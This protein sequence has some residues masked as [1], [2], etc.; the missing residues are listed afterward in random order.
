[1]RTPGEL[2][3]R[4]QLRDYLRTIEL[5]PELERERESDLARRY[6]EQGDRRAADLVISAHL[7]DVVAIARRYR[8]Y[9]QP[10]ADLIAAGN[11]GLVRALDRFDPDRGWRFMTYASY[12]V[13]AEILE[14]IVSTWSA[15][16]VGKSSVQRR[17]FFGLRQ[18]RAR[19]EARGIHGEALDE[20]LAEIFECSVERVHAMLE[21]LDQRDAPVDVLANVGTLQANPEAHYVHHEQLGLLG[22]GLDTLDPRERLII[23]RRFLADEGRTSRPEL[24]LELDISRE[25]VRQ[26]ENRA[27]AKLRAT[28]D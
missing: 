7:R 10:L 22:G 8:G 11:L 4:D 18:A 28:I 1:M 13:R 17:L 14:H 19:L 21:R 27:L 9:G 23:E 12:W 3:T 25:R 6:L 24:G 16:G 26:L 15:V 5:C 2:R 20:A